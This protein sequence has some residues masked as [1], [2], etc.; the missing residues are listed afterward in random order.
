RPVRAKGA[1]L[2]GRGSVRSCAPG[3]R[4]RRE[5]E[6]R[7]PRSTRGNT[8]TVQR[9]FKRLVRAR[10]AKTGESYTA[11]RARLLAGTVPE[12]AGTGEEV[13]QLV[14]PDERIRE[15]TGRGWEEWFDLLDTWDARAMGHTEIARRVAG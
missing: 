14:C 6:W 3:R 7:G 9:S 2:S 5:R 8:M 1:R 11:A 4:G 15:R 10:M 12:A 13:P